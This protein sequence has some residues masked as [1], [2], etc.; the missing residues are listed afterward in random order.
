MG[1]RA[2]GLLG[3]LFTGLWCL[4]VLF[5]A[6]PARA[7]DSLAAIHVCVRPSIVPEGVA[8][9]VFTANADSF[10][11]KIPRADFKKQ[12]AGLPVYVYDPYAPPESVKLF[13]KKFSNLVCPPA[14]APVKPPE[15]PAPKKD[16]PKAEDKK[17]EGGGA[18]AADPK[19]KHEKQ[20]GDEEE[21]PDLPKPLTR[22]P[23]PEWH[24][25]P[26]KG[27]ITEGWPGTVLPI[28]VKPAVLP[29]VASG[30]GV[31]PIVGLDGKGTVLPMANRPIP[32]DAKT[33][34][35][36]GG[37]DAGKKGAGPEKTGYEKWCEQV[38]LL[39]GVASLN[40]NEDIKAPAGS[41]YGIPGGKNSD[42]IKSP[43]AQAIAG[44]VMV[45]S[46]VITAGGFDKK[47]YDALAKG[48]RLFIRGGG[49]AGEQ[50]AE[51]L[52]QNAIAKYGKHGAEDLAGALAKNGAI[53]EYSVMSKFT[54]NLGGRYQAH[55]I[56]EVKFAEKFALGATDRIPAV[57]LSEAEHK[58][59]TATLAR[60]TMNVKTP[61]ALWAAYQRAYR[62][63][64]AWLKVIEGY[65]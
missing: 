6:R 35:G 40:L 46:A 1:S 7:D 32:S 47:F 22:P 62:L 3:W 8:V 61:Q 48:T 27:G 37:K 4:F 9:W 41:K 36:E 55:H 58:A 52:V 24:P 57:I 59:I 20:E 26:P 18:I 44:A 2:R 65:F 13:P 49:K 34:T 11:V 54:Q 33:A 43:T 12:A 17:A 28:Q 19:K 45:A 23:P 60:E 53:G 25:Q 15:A 51:K 42:G 63:H 30:H 31:L 39:G 29:S 64:P 56:L 14:P 16:Q 50:V 21:P 5:I 38:G 10:I